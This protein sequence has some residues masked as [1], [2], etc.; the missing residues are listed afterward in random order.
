MKAFS[1]VSAWEQSER[2]KHN[3]LVWLEK[4]Q[5]LHITRENTNAEQRVQLFACI[6]LLI[7]SH[8]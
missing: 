7:P 2:C 4:K 5:L 6:T 1:G 3:L 8:F